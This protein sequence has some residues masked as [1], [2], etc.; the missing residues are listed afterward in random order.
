MMMDIKPCPFCGR[1]TDLTITPE[2]TYNKWSENGGYTCIAVK[3][4]S[5]NCELI[6]FNIDHEDKSYGIIVSALLK[7][8]NSRP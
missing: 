5:C 7:R 6:E 4:K 2:E 3:C 1:V 8:W